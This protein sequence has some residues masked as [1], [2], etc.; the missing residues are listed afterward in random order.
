MGAFIA[1][2]P[3]GLLCRYSTIVDSVTHINMTEEE[4]DKQ[5][6]YNEKIMFR[7]R[8][9]YEWHEVEIKLLNE[10]KESRYNVYKEMGYSDEQIEKVTAG[11]NEP[12]EEG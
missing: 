10:T 12:W 7:K 9:I 1:R 4:C 3:N 6:P 8:T 2:Q 5:Y 11:F